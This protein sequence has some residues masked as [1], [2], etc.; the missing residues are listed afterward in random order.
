[1]VKRGGVKQDRL[2]EQGLAEQVEDFNFSSAEGHSSF[3]LCLLEKW[4]WGVLSASS[5][6]ELAHAAY[7]SGATT[8][9]M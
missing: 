8:T 9:D 5:E 3:G 6:Q 2:A 1:M 7:Q 4:A